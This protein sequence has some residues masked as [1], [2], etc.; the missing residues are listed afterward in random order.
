MRASNRQLWLALPLALAVL[1][2]AWAL[3]AGAASRAR[4]AV[5]LAVLGTAILAAVLTRPVSA[6]GHPAGVLIVAARSFA[7]VI[8]ALGVAAVWSAILATLLV[9]TVLFA[10]G[11]VPQLYLAAVTHAAVAAT[12]QVLTMRMPSRAVRHLRCTGLVR[13]PSAVSATAGWKHVVRAVETA[14]EA[15][16]E[17]L[18]LTIVDREGSAVM[19]ATEETIQGPCELRVREGDWLQSLLGF[20]WVHYTIDLVPPAKPTGTEVDLDDLCTVVRE[21]RLRDFV[22]LASGRTMK[23]RRRDEHMEQGVGKDQ[24]AHGRWS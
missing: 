4:P 12:L 18:L 11:W 7:V 23:L 8:R 20:R 5:L 13:L 9:L 16:Q 17:P 2:L 15:R 6:A 3:S 1:P 24:A 10:P 19:S 14:L 22:R 21:G